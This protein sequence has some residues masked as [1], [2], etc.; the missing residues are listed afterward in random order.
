MACEEEEE[1]LVPAEDEEEGDEAAGTEDLIEQMV[2]TCR[3]P[4]AALLREELVQVQAEAEVDIE[5]ASSR[6]SSR[7]TVTTQCSTCLRLPRRSRIHVVHLLRT[8]RSSRRLLQAAPEEML[9]RQPRR[10]RHRARSP[11]P[12]QKSS[13]SCPTGSG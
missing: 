11:F 8:A 5:L 4:M 10:R 1:E 2:Q 9:P 6:R 12:P 13:S 7:G 3:I